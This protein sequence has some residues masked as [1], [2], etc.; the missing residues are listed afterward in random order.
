MNETYEQEIDLKWLLYRVLRAW[1]GI[2]VWAI[3]IATAIGV[4]GCVFNLF[5]ISDPEYVAEQEANFRRAYASWEAT[6][7]NLKAEIE[8]LQD[9][10]EK[11]LEYN[12]KSVLMQIN[13]LREYNASFQLY[14]DYDY[15]IDPSLSYQNID[16][17][18][19]IIKAYATYMTNGEMYQYIIENLSYEMELRYFKEI[20]EVSADY[21]NNMISI[22]VRHESAEKCQ[23][24]LRLAAAGIQAKYDSVQ[25]TIAEHTLL[26]MNAAQYE[27]VNLSLDEMQK[28]NIQYISDVDIKLQEKNEEYLSWKKEPEPEA[29]YTVSEVVKGAIKT[30][31]I[32]GVVSGVVLAVVVAFVALLSGKLLNPE[33][34]KKRFGLRLIGE[35]PTVRVKKPFAFVSRW[36]AAFGGITMV[37]EDYEH[38]A[39]AV[40]AGLKSELS[41]REEAK[42][43]KTVAF[44]GTVSEEELQ[45][46]I[47]A[48]KLEGNYKV[49][50]VADILTNAES[51]EKVAA[52]DCVVLVEKQEVSRLSD[53][54]KEL[55]ALKAWNK[56]VLGAIVLNADAVL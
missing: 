39:C 26:E 54:S 41:A 19:R 48:M 31:V 30:L 38:L 1:R 18:D 28:A 40:A 21:T 37:P 4:G 3:V 53:I 25:K 36:F 13:P 51:V 43:W 24:I 55:E 8:N 50:A 44:A 27:T 16:L 7:A 15:Q 47:S 12:E 32:A 45:T 42:D 9:S 2:V 11:Q 35:L 14:V 20:F 17:S 56:T 33:D 29:E 34:M 46:L 6:G 5:K 22:S 52:A 10:R 23:E 49:T